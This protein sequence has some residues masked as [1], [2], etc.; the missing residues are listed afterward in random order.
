MSSL[1]TITS[2]VSSAVSS[3]KNVASAASST[4]GAV[5]G[6]ANYVVG[7][8]KS[9]ASAVSK[10]S[11]AA[12]S[13]TSAVSG[14]TSGV[15]NSRSLARINQ[16][17]ERLFTVRPRYYATDPD[18][19]KRGEA[20][21]IR[22]IS[23]KGTLESSEIASMLKSSPRHEKAAVTKMLSTGYQEF[24]LSDIN[25]QIA[26]KHQVFQTFGGRDAVYF[27]GR[28]PI[29]LQISGYVID[30]LD[31]DQ[32]A[33]MAS[34]YT[35][36]LRG[37]RLAKNYSIV[38][39][40]LPNA[41]FFG[42][43]TAINF[44][45][46]ADRDT[47]VRFT[48]TFVVRDTVFR[49]TDTYFTD[50]SGNVVDYQNEN[51]LQSAELPI[52]QAVINAKSADAKAVIRG[53]TATTVAN[54]TA[55]LDIAG[56]Y[57]NG[58]DIIPSVADLLGGFSLDD[59]TGFFTKW[60]NALGEV[61]NVVTSVIDDVTSFANEAVAYIGA[62]EAG[63]D[64]FL[65]TISNVVVQFENMIDT[66]KDAYGTIVNFP[67]TLTNKIGRFISNG[68]IEPAGASIIGSRF[69]SAADAEAALRVLSRND[70]GPIRGT[71][72]VEKLVNKNA[73]DV[74]IIDAEDI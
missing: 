25:Y 10:V 52:T 63:I 36:H 4:V 69:V 47:D 9:A 40:S 22:I 8:A 38:E 58:V 12:S 70:A 19:P 46:S 18:N 21:S 55:G 16:E 1:G 6:A 56:I 66:V 24:I 74:A 17:G 45:Q 5:S 41:T 35:N 33:K 26:E 59:L 20:A 62:I 44:N 28:A 14:A 29:M 65:S 13:L 42:A 2:S 32:F 72:L 48:M 51:F 49:S 71:D 39:L 11:S 43:I 50:D 68:F 53:T 60:N 54:N 30:D 27:Y 37:T 15:G 23:S 34:A 7:S 57:Q 67:E 61:L 64:G 3:V 31:N 73:D